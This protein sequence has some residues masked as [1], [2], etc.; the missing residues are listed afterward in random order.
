MSYTQLTLQERYYIEIEI[1]SRTSQN[2]IAREIKS[3]S[4]E[5]SW[6]QN[7]I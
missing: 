5:G 3:S 6:L 1:K 2:K 7:S 4:K